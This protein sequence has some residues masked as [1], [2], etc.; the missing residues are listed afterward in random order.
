MSERQFSS[1]NLR[2]ATSDM[3]RNRIGG[4]RAGQELGIIRL[5]SLMNGF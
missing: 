4:Y 3:Y 1:E 5:E 2:F